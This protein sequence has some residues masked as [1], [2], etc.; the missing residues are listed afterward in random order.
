M[1]TF[2]FLRD[3]KEVDRFAGASVEKLRETIK[4]HL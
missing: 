1:P 2:L 4:A 3:G